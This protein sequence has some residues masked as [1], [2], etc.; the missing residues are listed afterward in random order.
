MKPITSITV[1]LCIG[2][3]LITSSCKKDNGN[4]DNTPVTP[5]TPTWQLVTDSLVS[6]ITMA[7]PPDDSKRLFIAD[8]AGKIWVIGADGSKLSTPF[9][10]ITSKMVT[11]S[12]GYDERGL[13]GLA[14]SPSFKTNGK[15]YLFYSAPPRPGGPKPGASWNNLTRISEFTLASPTANVADLT[16]E[17]VLLEADHPYL[18]HNGGTIAFGPDGYLYISIGDGGNKDDVGDG[19]VDDWYKINAGGNA[20]NLEAN[21]M[22]KVLRIDVN[23]SPYTV[24]ADNPFVGTTAKPEIYAFGF[25]NPYRFSFDMGGAHQLFLGDAGQSLYE[26]VDIVTKGGNYG[27]NVKEGTHCFSTDND[28]IERASCPEKDSAGNT[29]VDPVIELVNAANP[30][31][32]GVGVTVVGGNVYRGTAIP[33]WL[34]KYIFGVY[35]QDG[36]ANAKI[37]SADA[38]ASGMWP[39]TTM[40]LK[41]V[42]DN[43]GQYL[44]GIGQ[45]QSGEVYLLTSGQSGQQGATGKVYK[46]VAAK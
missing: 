9:I 21:F 10:D 40:T 8:Q 7:E 37:F 22:G 30:K 27:W 38:A 33:N 14:F 25:R 17:R 29:L 34:G 4:G 41:D 44:K 19:H 24:P 23:G 26:E 2:I 43:L 3:T 42:G 36:S 16:T 28:L 35:S 15:F 46:I 18:N 11:L 32:G 6:P 20:Q 1:L 31:G 5:V 12:P 39:Y 45:D 13:L